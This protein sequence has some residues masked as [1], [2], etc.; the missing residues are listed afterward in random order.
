MGIVI[1]YRIRGKR[2]RKSSLVLFF[3]VIIIS[4][5]FIRVLVFPWLSC[6][7]LGP[8]VLDRKT[9]QENGQKRSCFGVTYEKEMH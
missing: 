6:K 7:S 1:V 3:I 9:V 8:S 2:K 4:S 5:I